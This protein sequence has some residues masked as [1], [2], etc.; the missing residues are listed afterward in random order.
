ML[1]MTKPLVD[2]HGSEWKSSWKTGSLERMGYLLH[3]T[4]KAPGVSC[5]EVEC[6]LASCRKIRDRP[7]PFGEQVRVN[8]FRDGESPQG[9]QKRRAPFGPRRISH[10]QR[11]SGSYGGLHL[12]R[13]E[14]A[15]VKQLSHTRN[16]QSR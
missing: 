6:S 1:V 14:Q 9:D 7:S 4:H 5:I 10:L 12:N 15:A 8:T 3:L 16:L 2:F 13:F 11:G